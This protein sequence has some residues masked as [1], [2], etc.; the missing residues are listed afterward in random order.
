MTTN[1]D[2][3]D[4]EEPSVYHYYLDFEGAGTLWG[5]GRHH[6]RVV[7]GG[8]YTREKR[9]TSNTI[10]E[11]IHVTELDPDT[12]E[13]TYSIS[14]PN[15]PSRTG[16][17]VAEGMGQ[18]RAGRGDTPKAHLETE[19]IPEG[20]IAHNRASGWP[21]RPMASKDTPEDSEPEMM[22]DGGTA[23]SATT[24][25]WSPF[26][27]ELGGDAFGT[28]WER[29]EEIT[30]VNWKRVFPPGMSEL[31][32]TGFYVRAAIGSELTGG[33]SVYAR[34]TRYN[35]ALEIAVLTGNL[36]VGENEDG[37]PVVRLPDGA[38][39]YGRHGPGGSDE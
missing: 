35:P 34:E 22:T 12:G 11:R 36:E 29:V 18:I 23:V 33:T 19:P 13:V 32:S 1:T 28:W 8:T 15:T 2:P 38:V 10:T 26:T 6:M 31:D 39:G 9:T 21:S 25:E 27:P 17:G 16:S 20:V 3:D 7:E 5:T 30:S 4:S 14:Q 37:D 24:G